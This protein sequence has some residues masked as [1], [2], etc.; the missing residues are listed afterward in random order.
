MILFRR[1]PVMVALKPLIPDINTWR[2][3]L[4]AGHFRPISVSH[5]VAVMVRAELATHLTTPSPQEDFA[6]LEKETNILF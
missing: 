3:A 2:E 1:I 4:F 6:E 5:F